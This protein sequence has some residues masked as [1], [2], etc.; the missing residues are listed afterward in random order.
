MCPSAPR[1]CSEP[2]GQ[3]PVLSLSLDLINSLW[4]G[5]P[6]FCH[7]HTCQIKQVAALLSSVPDL[8]DRNKILRCGDLSHLHVPDCNWVFFYFVWF[9]FIHHNFQFYF[10]LCTYCNILDIYLLWNL[11]YV[12]YLL[13]YMKLLNY[14]FCNMFGSVL[15]C[16]ELT[17]ARLL[18][19]RRALANKAKIWLVWK[20][21][22]LY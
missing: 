16:Y 13:F 10:E 6:R 17:G 9:M 14:L 21:I 3:K 20:K 2:G 22:G 1:V 15:E 11:N 8:W 18:W 5:S 4:V 7:R 19:T 12:N